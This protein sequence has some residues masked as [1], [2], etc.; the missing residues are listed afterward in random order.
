[1]PVT[2]GTKRAA[3][4]RPQNTEEE[5]D[6]ELDSDF[7]D[8]DLGRRGGSVEAMESDSSDEDETAQEKKMR[9]TM[10]YLEEIRKM[11]AAD[12]DGDEARVG[13]DD[14]VGDHLREEELEKAGKLQKQIA[15]KCVQ[16]AGA[17]IRSYKHELAVTSVVVSADE[18]V[19]FSA[20]KN[21][22]IIKWDLTAGVTEPKKLIVVKGGKL[23][24]PKTA[25]TR[26]I[27][28]LAL[29]T[30]NKFLASAGFD[31]TIHIWN[32]ETMEHLKMFKGH[33]DH[34][35]SLSFRVNTHV[36]FSGSKD[37]TIKMWNLDQMGYMETLYG[38]ESPVL[39]LDCFLRD[40]CISAAKKV[41]FYDGKMTICSYCDVSLS[42]L[43][44]S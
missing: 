27:L 19:M 24:D 25:H 35:T 2:R 14:F 10:N 33:R 16:P 4:K 9:L 15:D 37:R 44:W 8:D 34:V 42:C 11:K 26:T 22:R 20:S 17:D 41:S 13:D 29:T 23:Y 7:S 31:N 5:R 18:T 39:S 21:A 40:R 36:L 12:D 30:D 43:G 1:M 38:H 6:E 32:P 3:E 28:A